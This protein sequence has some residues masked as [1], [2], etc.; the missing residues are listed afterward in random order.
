MLMLT[1]EIILSCQ[2]INVFLDVWDTEAVLDTHEYHLGL[3]SAFCSSLW[4]FLAGS[5]WSTSIS[6]PSKSMYCLLYNKQR[7]HVLRTYFKTLSIGAAQQ[8]AFSQ[9]LKLAVQKACFPIKL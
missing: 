2:S 7:Q 1:C 4:G 9:I 6:W 5:F 8:Q 3:L